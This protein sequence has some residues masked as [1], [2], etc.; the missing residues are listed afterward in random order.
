[1]KKK[2]EEKTTTIPNHILMIKIQKSKLTLRFSVFKNAF[3]FLGTGPTTGA[4]DD[5]PSGI[6]TY[7]QAGAK[8]GLG[9][10]WLAIFQYPLMTAVQEMCA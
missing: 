2:K 5:D 6:A 3:K 7:F 8:F 9:M 10:L 4:S 1:M